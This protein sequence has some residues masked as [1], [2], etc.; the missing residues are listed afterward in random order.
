[1]NIVGYKPVKVETYR[2]ITG[3]DIRIGDMIIAKNI[4]YI[5][6]AV[7][8]FT[9]QGASLETGEIITFEKEPKMPIIS[10][11]EMIVS[12]EYTLVLR[13]VIRRHDNI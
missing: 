6:I 3:K 7:D 12:Y 9:F 4:L 13:A 11:G 1:M 5:V 10:N 8:K 2:I